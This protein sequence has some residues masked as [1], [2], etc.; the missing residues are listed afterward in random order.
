MV[1]ASDTKPCGYDTATLHGCGLRDDDFVRAF[2]RMVRR[3]IK[4][5]KEKEENLP[6]TP[7][8]L[9]ASFDEGPFPE[10][11]NAIFYTTHDSALINEY[12]YEVTSTV[13]ATKIWSI[14][15]DSEY[16][17]T[18]RK[19]PSRLFLGWLYIEIPTVK[20]LASDDTYSQ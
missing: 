8:E 10:L 7:E 4:V 3:K 20:K 19:I 13:K 18:K 11:Y 6:M 9:L 1:Y 14:A 16:L 2:G 15:S 12:G 5:R 17:I